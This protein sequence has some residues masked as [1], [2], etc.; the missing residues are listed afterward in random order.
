MAIKTTLVMSQGYFT[1]TESHYQRNTSSLFGNG[2][3]VN[4]PASQQAIQLANAR[5]QLL[6]KGAAIVRVRNSDTTIPRSAFDLPDNSYTAI[7]PFVGVVGQDTLWAEFADTSLLMRA[8]SPAFAYSKNFYLAGLPDGLFDTE[9]P[10]PDGLEWLGPFITPFNAYVNL[11]LGTWNFRTQGGVFAPAQVTQVV[12]SAQFPNTVGVVTAAQIA[13]QP[14]PVAGVV[15]PFEVNLTGF[16]RNNTRVPGLSGRYQVVGVV[17]PAG[18]VTTYTYFL[19]ET[20]NVVP[21]NLTK[22]G[23]IETISY[24]YQPYGSIAA[25]RAGRRKRG[26]R[27]GRPLGRSK[28]RI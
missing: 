6:G 18:A 3:G 2:S 12:T 7:G 25:T 24:S 21:S 22:M 28:S 20:G 27:T 9:P 16:R 14:A 15:Q 10:N 17:L 13:G 8:Y 26:V 23:A 5:S 19:G 11:L 1:W 4:S